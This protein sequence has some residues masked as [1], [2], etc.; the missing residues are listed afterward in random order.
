MKALI[1]RAF[2]YFTRPEL[3]IITQITNIILILGIIALIP[4]TIM[5]ICINTAVDGIIAEIILFFVAVFLLWYMS[6]GKGDQFPVAMALIGLNA[7]VFPMLFFKTGGRT[8]GIIIWMFLGAAY[9]AFLLKSIYRILSYVVNIIV[10]VVC[11]YVQHFNQNRVSHISEFDECIDVIVAY[12]VVLLIIGL[13][14]QIQARLYNKQKKEIEQKEAKLI[15]L[16]EKLKGASQAKSSFLANMSHEIR[17]PINAVLGMDEMIIRDALDPVILNY[18]KDIDMAGKQLLSLVNDVLDLAKMEDGKF[19]LE[20]SDYQ[21]YSVL[22]DCAKIE[23]TKANDKKISLVFDVD[24]DIPRT[25]YGDENRIK[26]IVLNLISNGIKYTPK[27]SVSV[28]VGYEDEPDETITLTI[29]VTDT[30]LGIPEEKLEHI[31]LDYDQIGEAKTVDGIGLGLCISKQLVELMGG[32]ID[33]KSKYGEGSTFLV[34]IPQTVVDRDP[35]GDFS[36][37]NENNIVSRKAHRHSFTAEN[38]NLLVVDDVLVNLN[39]VRLLLRETKINIDLAESGAEALEY[40]S[41]KHYDIVL[42][43]HVMPKMDGIETLQRIRK[44][45]GSDNKD[46]PVI[47]LTANTISGSDSIYAAAG[48][49]DYLTKPVKVNELERSLIEYLPAD[50]VNITE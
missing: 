8:T 41:K 38:A 44:M 45:E 24:K 49:C 14:F 9:A 26:Q 46:I 28:S 43:D 21:I 48:F 6:S 16:N 23:K 47:A 39:V 32:T 19:D 37:E 3:D 50:K 22:Y 25:L 7:I 35:S 15:E 34:R 17:T 5:S 36:I 10:F 29:S 40:L 42:M 12:G 20:Y 2:K 18:A 31:F 30:G 27:G 1:K 33:V 4:C 11:I 13:I